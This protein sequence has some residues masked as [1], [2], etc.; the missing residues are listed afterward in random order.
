MKNHN[1]RLSKLESQHTPQDAAPRIS[2]EEHLRS[3]KALAEAIAE[4]ASRQGITAAELPALA[5]PLAIAEALPQ[6][7]QDNRPLGE[8][9]TSGSDLTD[10]P[11]GRFV[12]IR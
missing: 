7:P 12:E 8:V 2:D 1:S 4:E 5:L 6:P 9:I 3:M 10:N 11:G